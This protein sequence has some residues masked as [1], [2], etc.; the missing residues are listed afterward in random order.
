MHEYVIYIITTT[1][2]EV[3]IKT[4]KEA[5]RITGGGITKGNTKMPFWSYGISAF[6]CK[7]GSR[8]SAVDET[9]CAGC[10]AKKGRY[11]FSHV[12][13]AFK[14]RTE[15]IKDKLWVEA[16]T[17]QIKRYC[18]G[19]QNYFRWHDT[20]DLQ[21]LNHFE[22][23][24]KIANNCPDVIFWLPTREIDIILKARSK[25]IVP[26]KNLMV[27]VSSHMLGQKPF[28]NLPKWCTTSTV[29]WEES[30]NNCPA[31]DQGNQCG[32]CRNCW[33]SEVKNVNYH[34][35]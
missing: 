8:L 20:G 16:M 1:H 26:P 33:T 18:V 2:G 19:N 24:I 28:K 32:E 17:F 10:Y 25:G 5:K 22:N 27:R 15:S 21:D 11:L 34:K 31:P 14:L 13:K 7:V 30:K 12:K 4:V 6:D 29:D 9:V 23:I 3:M 35:H